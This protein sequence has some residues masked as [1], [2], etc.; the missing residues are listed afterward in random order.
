[1]TSDSVSDTAR[2]LL[3]DP[4]LS[5]RLACCKRAYTTRRVPLTAMAGLRDAASAQPRAGD[6]VLARVMQMGKHAHL[7][8]VAGRRAA[9]FVGDEI[10]V[11]YAARYAPDQYEA[12]LPADAGPCHLVAGGGVAAEVVSRHGAVAAP[13]RIEPLALVTDSAG[14]PLNLADFALP[15]PRTAA[16]RHSPLILSVGTS[17]NAGK[18]TSAAWLIR[19]LTRAGLAVGAAKVTG[20]GAGLDPNLMRD[21][22]AR[23]VL[24]FIDGGYASTS[25]LASAELVALFEHLLKALRTQPLDAIVIE[26]ADGLFQPET[27]ALLRA[28]EL[29]RAVAG[30]MV[31]AGEAMGAAACAHWLE[32][33]GLPVLALAGTMTRS[34]LARAEAAAATGLPVLGLDDLGDPLIARE[35]LA[36]ATAAAGQAPRASALQPAA[37]LAGTDHG[38][39]QALGLT[40]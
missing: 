35:L 33:A 38:H 11:S 31:S 2:K 13:T 15:V 39:R 29:A 5:S 20:T 40:G 26:I 18:S 27:A 24:D 16:T 12:R 30:V 37:G 4:T 1:M 28:P 25:G 10:L 7:E 21:A 22:G 36:K 3:G 34:A 9:L 23:P 17:M 32:K 6:L 19:G 14:Q 8:N